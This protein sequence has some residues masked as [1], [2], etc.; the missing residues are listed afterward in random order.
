MGWFTVLFVAGNVFLGEYPKLDLKKG[1]D[2]NIK[3]DKF[4]NGLFL[5]LYGFC[6]F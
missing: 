4:G 5:F 1:L 6:Y 2:I 3:S